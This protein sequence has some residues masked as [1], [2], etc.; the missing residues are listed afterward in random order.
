MSPRC[1]V[2]RRI[3]QKAR[4][5]GMNRKPLR[6]RKRVGEFRAVFGALSQ[7]PASER[8]SDRTK[9]ARALIRLPVRPRQCCQLN[10]LDAVAA[11]RDRGPSLLIAPTCLGTC[12]A[13]QRS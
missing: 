3:S 8:G 2:E 12:V 10:A 1:H 5:G 9:L 7:S 13:A 6:P 4:R 11:G